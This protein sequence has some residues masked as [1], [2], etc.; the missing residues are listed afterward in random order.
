MCGLIEEVTSV[1]VLDTSW[2]SSNDV[3]VYSSSN[4]SS[5]IRNPCN[6]VTEPARK[7]LLVA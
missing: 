4:P 2:I 7:K 5:K 3:R 6:W 1:R